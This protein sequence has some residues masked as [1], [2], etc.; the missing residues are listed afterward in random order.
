M[1]HTVNIVDAI[2]GTGKTTAMIRYINE[3]PPDRRFIF[4][5]PYL[6][7]VQR[8]LSACPGKGFV[9]PDDKTATKLVSIKNLIADDMNIATTHA[10]FMLLDDEA[11]ELIEARNYTLIIDEAMDILGMVDITP[12]DIKTI[13]KEYCAEDPDGKLRWEVPEYEGKFDVYRPEIEAGVVYRSSPI[14]LV[15][16]ANISTFSAF[17]EVFLMTYLFDGQIHKSYFDMYGWHYK[18]WFVAGNDVDTYRLTPEPVQ[19][20]PRDYSHLISIKH[21]FKGERLVT[22]RG[23][24]SLSWYNRNVHGDGQPTEQFNILKKHMTSFFRSV[25]KDGYTDPMWTTFKIYRKPLAASG[26]SKGFLHCSAKATNEYR[27]KNALAY[28]V[29]RYINPNLVNFI[30]AHG[31]K[32]DHNAFALSEMVQWVWRS[33]IRDGKPI[34][35]YI[36]SDRMCLLFTDWLDEISGKK[37]LVGCESKESG[38]CLLVPCS[39]LIQQPDRSPTPP[40]IHTIK[41]H[42]LNFEN[43]PM[44]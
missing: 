26:Y 1:D 29:N 17:Q 10:L 44:V 24:F 34:V 42:K 35:L 32:I 14:S 39:G 37:P 8:V 38:H 22:S 6:E 41:S 40:S 11:R 9:E 36:P 30:S 16:I 20:Q 43:S 4:C 31:G 19:Y 15:R 18:H 27:S 21:H 5:T 7:Q 23:S 25:Y 12:Y 33:A 2:M 13:C 28:P 3:S